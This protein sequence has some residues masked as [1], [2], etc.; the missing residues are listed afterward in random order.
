MP[1]EAFSSQYNDKRFMGLA[2]KTCN[3]SLRPGNL[4]NVTMTL[5]YSVAISRRH[6]S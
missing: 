5:T 2:R 1:T 4:R 3:H 6:A